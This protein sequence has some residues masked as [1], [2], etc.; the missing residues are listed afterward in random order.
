MITTQ[1]RIVSMEAYRIADLLT[2]EI[3]L[4]YGNITLIVK[5]GKVEVIRQ[6]QESIRRKEETKK[7]NL[8]GT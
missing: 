5:A 8:P 2:Q 7:V 6:Q 3:G 4:E 1:A